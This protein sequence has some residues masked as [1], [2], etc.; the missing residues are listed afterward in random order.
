M[1]RHSAYLAFGLLLFVLLACN[2]SK[3]EN[4]NNNNAAPKSESDAKVLGTFT[5]RR[6]V[7]NKYILVEKGISD[8]KL[9]EVAKKLHEDEPEANFWFVDDDSKADEMIKWVKD[10]ENGEATPSDPVYDW[11]GDHIVGNV[12]QY[13]GQGGTKYWALAKGMMGDQITKLD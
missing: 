10:Y 12:Q 3:K 2:F 6:N 4:S 7:V 5:N 8:E 9:T 13:F 1:T 11:M